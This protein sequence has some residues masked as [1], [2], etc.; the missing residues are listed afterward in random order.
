MARRLLILSA[1]LLLTMVTGASSAE[2]K[3]FASRAIWTVLKEVGPAF[4]RANGHKLAV[5]TG[6]STAFA[7]HINAGEPFDLMFAPPG[8]LDAYIKDGK[9]DPAT[10]T[11]L[12]SSDAGVGIR[13]PRRRIRRSG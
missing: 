2:L 5:T 1:I 7:K 6:L 3:I 12:V 4:E 11:L 8:T 10:R 9:L 13:A